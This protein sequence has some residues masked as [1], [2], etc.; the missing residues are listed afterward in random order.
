MPFDPVH[1]YKAHE[2]SL[3]LNYPLSSIHLF[4]FMYPSSHV[5]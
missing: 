1:V 3:Y 4:F 2:L 5:L